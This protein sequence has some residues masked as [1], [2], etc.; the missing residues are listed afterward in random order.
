MNEKALDKVKKKNAAFD[1]YLATREGTDFLKYAKAKNQAKSESR[2]AV[3]DYVRE[4]VKSSK[5][6]HQVTIQI[7]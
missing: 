1:Q 3:R 2:K 6:H 5:N 4:I 7:R